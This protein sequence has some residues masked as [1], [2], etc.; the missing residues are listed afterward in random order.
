MYY[1]CPSIL[2]LS[3]EVSEVHHRLAT[4]RCRPPRSPHVSFGP[5][6]ALECTGVRYRRSE[7]AAASSHAREKARV[8]HIM[9][10]RISVMRCSTCSSSRLKSDHGVHRGNGE[11]AF[12]VVDRANVVRRRGRDSK[13]FDR[14]DKV[15]DCLELA[16]LQCALVINVSIS[17]VVT[18]AGVIHRLTPSTPVVPSFQDDTHC[19]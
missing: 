18:R 3:H 6:L 4:H 19:M 11:S 1:V 12:H 5:Q 2:R 15:P 8:Q 10:D 16:R 9:S 13:P 14:W 7:R 17:P